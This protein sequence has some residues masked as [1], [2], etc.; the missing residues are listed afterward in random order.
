AIRLYVPQ[1]YMVLTS[2]C[3]LTGLS[4]GL[5]RGGRQEGMR[6]LAE[7]AHRAP[8]TMRGWYLYKK[9]KNYRMMWGGLREGGREAVK[10]GVVGLAFAAAE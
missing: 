4:L 7:N 6:F 8:T 2:V 10:L 3:G 9:T 1:R 5:L